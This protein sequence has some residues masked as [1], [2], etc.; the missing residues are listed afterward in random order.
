MT[1]AKARARLRAAGCRY[2]LRAVASKVREG[3]VVS[4]SRAA[5]S[6]TSAT[7]VVKVSRG[8]HAARV[9]AA[10]VVDPAALYARVNDRLT[11][12]QEAATR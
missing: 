4:T 7:V 2:T 12:A 9:R 11:A 1:A 6:R 8:R 5:G 10:S 3:R